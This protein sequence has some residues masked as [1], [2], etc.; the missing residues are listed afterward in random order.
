MKLKN[1]FVQGKMNKDIDE[2]LLPKGQY[3]HAENIR[4]ANSDGSD[5]GAIENVRGAKQLTNLNL[6]N[7]YVIG[8]VADD[9][10]RKIYYFITSDFIDMVVEFDDS[11]GTLGS[12][13]QSTAGTGVL[14]FSRDN[15]ITGV[16]KVINEDSSKDLLFWTDNRNPPRVINIERFTASAL[17]SFTEDDISVIKAP[18]KHAPTYTFSLTTES[19]I[20]SIEDK[21]FSFAYRYKYLDGFYSAISSWTEYAYSPNV[22]DI[23]F[24][25]LENNGMR[26]TSNALN[27]TM[28]KGGDNVVEVQLVLKESNSN[29]VYIVEKFNRDDITSNIDGDFTYNFVNDKTLL[30]L[31]VDELMRSYDNVPL[32][33]KAQE[34]VNNRLMYG[35]YVEGFDIS[36]EDGVDIDVDYN[37]EVVSTPLEGE[38]LPISLSNSNMALN[39][40]LTGLILSRDVRLTIY[41]SLLGVG[42]NIGATYTQSFVFILERDYADLI[43]LT[44]S[45]E[46]ISFIDDTMVGIFDTEET[47]VPPADT[48]ETERFPFTFNL[49]GNQLQITAP[50]QIHTVDNT[51]LDEDIT[52]GD[53]TLV[54]YDWEFTNISESQFNLE[55]TS[56]SLKSNRNLEVGIVYMDN[57][58][59][60]STVTLSDTNTVDIPQ[61]LAI[62]Q[63]KLKITVNSEAPADAVA[64]KFAVKQNKGFYENIFATKFFIED[65]FVW[66]KLEQSNKDKVKA[67]D[68]L[69]V[70]RDS[71][72]VLSQTVK[73][74]VLEVTSQPR[75]FIEGNYFNQNTGELVG[76]GGGA[77]VIELIEPAGIYMKVKP[78]GFNM[79]Y[80]ANTFFRGQYF[81]DSDHTFPSMPVTG[82]R[83]ATDY[84]PIQQGG[85]VRLGLTNSV[86]RTSRFA[87]ASRTYVASADYDNFRDFWLAE[88][89]LADIEF[90]TG[91][92]QVGS[93]FGV[94]DNGTHIVV[95]AIYDGYGNRRTSSFWASITITNSNG[96]T[97]FETVPE[98][99]ISEIY[100]ETS[101]TFSIAEGRHLGKEQEQ[102][103]VDPAIH[104]LNFYNCFAMGEGVESIAYLD[105]FN[106]PHLNIDLRPTTTGVERFKR[107]RRYADITYSEV[108]NENSNLN[109]LNEFNLSKVNYKED[110]DKKYGFI[111]KLYTRDTN[112]VVFQEDKVSYI[113]FGKDLLMNADGTS[114]ITSAESILGQQIPYVGEY[115]ISKNP[116]S[117]AFNANSLYFTD[118]KRGCVCRLNL[119]GITEISR[120]GMSRFFKDEFKS[121]FN[122]HKLGVFDP[123]LDQYVL[124]TGLNTLTFDES[125]KGWT[126]FHTFSPDF[127][128]G[129]NNKLFSFKGGDLYEHHS[130][131]VLRNIYYG[132][133]YPSKVSLMFNDNPSEI[134]ELQSVVLEGNNTWNVLIKSFV[135][136]SD[137]FLQSTISNTEFVKKEGMWYAYARRNELDHYDSKSS[138]G[139]GSVVGVSG[140]TIS[141]I[142]VNSSLCVGDIIVRG[143]DLSTISTIT[144][145]TPTEFGVDIEL[146]SVGT[147]TE[148]DYV[149]GVKDSRVEGG[150]L[151]GYAIR[152]DLENYND[153]KTELFAVNA[154]IIKS[155]S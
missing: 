68:V 142:G 99:N 130:S 129:M 86:E 27:I 141:I 153:N 36:N 14:N 24:D 113:L 136:N 135:S 126:S 39:I 16:N 97:V 31:P 3:S 118:V 71:T 13:L 20:D 128:V 30:A 76:S 95:R 91:T 112:L 69:Y 78:I 52:D 127:M 43:D 50:Y 143:D 132:T 121:Q 131:E 11:N 92:A 139:L 47:S 125:V 111:Q 57:Y 148:G 21:F 4:V 55:R 12:L 59:R 37:V 101:E 54:Q 44:T 103:D 56:A 155:F 61:E 80:N 23:D 117:F 77:G 94:S 81:D 10:N 67:G 72:G 93:T 64:Y 62:L 19:S 109:G 60:K 133:Q 108:Y 42:A 53:V 49:T 17:D 25:T 79:N 106:K 5:I 82:R 144:E 6:P 116:E 138:Y 114:N 51:P 26:N 104:T 38:E 22:L 152:M 63:N 105:A 18:P 73:V 147:L 70:K 66:I 90:D 145:I 110:I 33:A 151:R 115:G 75:N 146:L 87:S 122:S 98:N 107:V 40:D 137:D 154:E 88:V 140:N 123:Y 102:T 32:L 74:T 134:K 85:T 65:Q 83:N 84:F 96:L 149:M 46:F 48:A 35:N 2:R 41:I 89:G 100:Y 15:L 9:S 58:N 119:N 7:A 8:S 29:T 34:I 1:T 150:N 28:N 45:P 120:A 124:N